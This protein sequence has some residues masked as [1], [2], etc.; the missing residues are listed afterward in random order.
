MMG[1]EDEFRCKEHVADAVACSHLEPPLAVIAAS[2]L[3]T[4]T[5]NKIIQR[6][7]NMGPIRQPPQHLIPMPRNMEPRPRHRHRPL[8][9][10]GH[11]M[12]NQLMERQC[13]LLHL[14]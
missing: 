1:N 12:G 5:R 9:Y 8:R 4:P 7:P 6:Q 3:P 13:R 2:L 14:G 11:R 10:Q